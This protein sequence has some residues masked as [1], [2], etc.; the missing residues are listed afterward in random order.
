MST[1]VVDRSVIPTLTKSVTDDYYS[2]RGPF[3]PEHLP[4]KRTAQE[5]S[6]DRDRALF[7]T[8]T[9]AVDYRKETAGEMGL[10]RTAKRIWNNKRWVF[11]PTQ[12]VENHSYYELVDRFEATSI[13]AWQD[14][15]IWYRN[16]LTLYRDFDSNP[17]T[18]LDH[19]DYDALDLLEYMN[20]NGTDFPYLKGDKISSLWLRLID[21]EV[22]ELSRIEEVSMPVDSRIRDLTSRLLETNYDDTRSDNREIAEFWADVCDEINYYPVQVDQPL[23]WIE[24]HW[25]EWGEG[26]FYNKIQE[27]N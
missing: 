25:N 6:G 8:L 10:W 9:V 14:P 22:H 17:L 7:L 5:I 20:E 12:L 2:E 3:R 19:I 1:F 11:E 16:A 18:L 13:M 24:K 4:G 27:V 26:Y 23:W 21:E 15:H